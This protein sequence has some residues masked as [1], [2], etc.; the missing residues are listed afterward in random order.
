MQQ[1]QLKGED[2]QKVALA[3]LTEGADFL[4]AMAQCSLRQ[5]ARHINSPGCDLT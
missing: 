4:A 3:C 5:V 1:E 2:D